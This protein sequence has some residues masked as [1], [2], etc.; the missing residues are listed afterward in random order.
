MLI[1]AQSIR[2]E[3]QILPIKNIASARLVERKF[4]GK[5]T[6][7]E[8]GKRTSLVLLAGLGYVILTAISFREALEFGF[9][10]G[11]LGFWMLIQIPVIKD[12]DIEYGVELTTNSGKT[13]LFWTPDRDFAEQVKNAI[14]TALEGNDDLRYSV[15][16]DNRTIVDQSVNTSVTNNKIVNDYSI[17]VKHYEGMSEEQMSFFHDNISTALTKLGEAVE[18]TS[19]PELVQ[20]LEKLVAT[21]NEEKPEPTKVSKAWNGFKALCDG[22]ESFDTVSKLVK[23]YGGLVTAGVAMLQQV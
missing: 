10:V 3:E 4:R 19:Q 12:K 18:K 21:L 17:N 16:I 8:Q 13:S 22:Y 23:E 9:L 20:Q 5:I 11:I 6:E 14:F 15:N 2:H 1:S 7:L